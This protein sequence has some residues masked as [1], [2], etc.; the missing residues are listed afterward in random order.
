[1]LSSHALVFD[2]IIE[3]IL[4]EVIRLDLN[5][6]VGR[7]FT[8]TKSSVVSIQARTCLIA[9]IHNPSRESH[10]LQNHNS[11]TGGAPTNLKTRAP[12][13]RTHGMCYKSLMSP[14]AR[15]LLM[16]F[17]ISMPVKSSHELCEHNETRQPQFE[18]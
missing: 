4:S 15:C 6:E 11:G 7:L 2:I 1:M 9:W 5:C 3:S 13:Q 14:E 10:A 8:L 12:K 17:I 18:V 16:M